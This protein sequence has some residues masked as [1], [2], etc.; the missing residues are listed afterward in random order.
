MNTMEEMKPEAP[1]VP[2]KPSDQ[3]QQAHTRYIEHE[4]KLAERRARQQAYR[5]ECET[6]IRV[7]MRM[8]DPEA[9]ERATL[10]LQYFASPQNADNY[11]ENARLSAQTRALELELGRALTQFRDSLITL[12]NATEQ[13]RIR[14]LEK[15]MLPTFGDTGLV[16]DFLQSFQ[17]RFKARDLRE[18]VIGST[19]LPLERQLPLLLELQQQ[20]LREAVTTEVSSA[21]ST[22][23]ETVLTA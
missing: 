22:V 14:R 3:A 6:R 19:A 23:E 21:R 9:A 13:E 4:A 5:D 20:I 16:A 18:S 12:A 15:A 1:A 8:G 10:D 7:A 2:V 17:P 11:A